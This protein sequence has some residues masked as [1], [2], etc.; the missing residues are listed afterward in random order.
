M[1]SGGSMLVLY[2]FQMGNL[3]RAQ[4]SALWRWRASP[5][6]VKARARLSGWDHQTKLVSNQTFFSSD[7]PY[8]TLCVSPNRCFFFKNSLWGQR[9]T[10]HH[11]DLLTCTQSLEWLFSFV[12]T[13][14]VSFSW[15]PLPH[16]TILSICDCPKNNQCQD[17]KTI[18]SG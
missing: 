10:W 3:W 11:H 13:L 15:A 5:E 6:G 14:S 18:N 9:A 1:L 16:K 4:C 8:E 12:P 2:S 7:Q 17:N